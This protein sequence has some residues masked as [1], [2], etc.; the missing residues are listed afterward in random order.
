MNP[1][2]TLLGFVFTILGFV[3]LGINVGWWSMDVWGAIAQL[4]PVLIV[5]A[6]L[7]LLLRNN[8]LFLLLSLL[9]IVVGLAI[10]SATDRTTQSSNRWHINVGKPLSGET[11]TLNRQ[12]PLT[13]PAV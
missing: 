2:R 5:I 12:S 4:W 9:A 11:S 7:R 8:A 3:F 6:G 13:R 1:G 10:A